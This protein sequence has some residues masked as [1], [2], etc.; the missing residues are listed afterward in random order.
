MKAVMTTKENIYDRGGACENDARD[1]NVEI[2]LHI[3][4]VKQCIEK[5]IIT[6]KH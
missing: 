2:S 5:K 4:E 1:K 3:N 6:G